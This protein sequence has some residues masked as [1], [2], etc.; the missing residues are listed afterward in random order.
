M[1]LGNS[2]A[3]LPDS[4][5]MAWPRPAAPKLCGFPSSAAMLGP[6]S[7]STSALVSAASASVLSSG[8]RSPPHGS[9][10]SF[11][12]PSDRA[13]L[14]P[15]P[16]TARISPISHHRD[17]DTTALPLYVTCR[18]CV[19]GTKSQTRCHVILH[20]ITTNPPAA[21]ST[22]QHRASITPTHGHRLATISAHALRPT[23]SS[24]RAGS[25]WRPP[26]GTSAARRW[27]TAVRCA[28]T[29]AI[30]SPPAIHHD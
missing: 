24:G 4:F 21:W 17:I 14:S 28:A 9:C 2:A 26:L 12:T 30:W 3:S 22:F 5:V 11:A 25:L 29:C 19:V 13:L 18:G 10:G 23:G 1:A 20:Q 16:I 7:G 27:R 8:R 6:C 15:T